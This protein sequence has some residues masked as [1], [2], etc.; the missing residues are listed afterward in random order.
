ME[1][2][3]EW[4]F[5]TFVNR[6]IPFT[7]IPPTGNE[8]GRK[9]IAMYVI[10]GHSRRCFTV[11]KWM[12][13][14]PCSTDIYSARKWKFADAAVRNLC[15]YENFCDYST[16]SWWFQL[17]FTHFTCDEAIAEVGHLELIFIS[18]PYLSFLRKKFM[19]QGE[20]KLK[21]ECPGKLRVKSTKVWT[22]KIDWFRS[23]G[24]HSPVRAHTSTRSRSWAW[25]NHKMLTNLWRWKGLWRW[26]LLSN[27]HTSH[28]CLCCGSG[29]ALPLA[30]KACSRLALS[31]VI[32]RINEEKKQRRASLTKIRHKEERFRP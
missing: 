25:R 32:G 5:L 16:L 6:P 26:V 9:P 12:W 1:K 17:P 14:H 4:F 24:K 8:R 19:V 29:L 10:A 18:C 22:K 28:C 7:Y 15:E 31:Y 13:Q 3:S 20:D 2:R 30:S 23:G 21:R 11:H 27:V